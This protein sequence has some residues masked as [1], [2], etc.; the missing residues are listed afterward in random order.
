MLTITYSQA[1]VT[2]RSGIDYPA[3]IEN[4]EI[5]G[6]N[7]EP[8]HAVLMPYGNM[9]EALKANRRASTFARSLNGNWKFN[10]VPSPEKRPVDFYKNDY[11]VSKWADIPVPSNWEVHGY[12][13]PFYRN[14]G[15]TIKKD[16]PHIMSE[17]DKRYTA[18]VERNPVGSYKRNFDVPADWNGRR[19][20][21]SFDGVDAG[22]FLWVNGQKVG[23]SVNSRNAAEFDLTRYVKPGKNTI[24]AEVYQYTSGT[25]LEDQD[26]WRLHGIFRNVT[27]WSAP[28]THIRDFFIKPELDKNF[29]NATVSVE[30]KLK[31][32]SEQNIKAQTV[33]ATLYNSS[34]TEVAK[35]N[36]SSTALKAGQE[37]K[38]TLKFPVDN[39]AKW[40]AETPNLYTVVLTTNEGEILSQK[41][42]FRKLEIR[43]RV[44]LVNGVPLK[45]KGVNRHE[46]WSDVGHAVT[47]EQM[48]KDLEV[49][50]QGNCN[51]VRT[52][53]YSNDP[54]W[55]ELC[56]EW[57]IWLVAEANMEY[58]G[59]DRKFDEEPTIKAAIVD[60]N[61]ANVENFK[62]HP[63]VIIWSLGN[64]GGAGGTNVGAAL[65]AVKAIDSS[66]FVHYERYGTGKN[67]PADLDGR[68]YGTAQDYVR[69][70]QDK[71]L[72][73]PLYICE[74]VHAM[75]NSM[76][77]LNEYSDAFDN[78]PEILGG[79]IW[80][81]QDQ[82]LWNRRDPKHPILAY[83]GGFGEFPN[84]HY[85]I[86]K[87]VVAWD[88]I[89]VKPHYPEMKKAFQ[90]ISTDMTDATTGTIR[91]KNKFQ[92][93]SLE[94]F[95]GSWTLTENGVEISRGAFTLPRVG[96]L[97]EGRAFI[98]FKVERPKP[99]AEYFLRVSYTQNNKTLWAD[100]G[101][102]VAWDQ[103]KLPINT[104]AITTPKVTQPVGLTQNAQLI[105]INGNGFSV[106]FDKKSGL[107]S[108]LVKNGANLLL[109]GGGPKIHLWRAA[110]RND[111]MWAHGIWEKYG[112]NN[113][114]FSLVDLKAQAVD[115]FTVKV[116][117]TIKGEGKDGFGVYHTSTYVVK[118]DG[119]I[120]VNN[121]MDFIGLP[122][123]LGRIGV[124]MMLNQ[125]L[126]R[127]QYFGRGPYE[128]YSDRKS[129]AD[130][131]LYEL[132]V[133]EQYEY[134]KPMDRGNHEEVRWVKFNGNNTPN[135]LVKANEHHMQFTALPHT[136]EQMFPVEYKIDLPPSKATV[137]CLSTKTLGVG[138]ASCGPRP[139]EKFQVWANNVAFS[140]TL[141]LGSK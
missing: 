6:I 13:T 42:G 12:G 40:T 21:V 73:K 101:Y 31:N 11:D 32:Y 99:G 8:H 98:P 69:I 87:G 48:I 29:V 114:Q 71:Q 108:Q 141:Q 89:T 95:S 103:F 44:F 109:P 91:I 72:T 49:I 112:V 125:D 53:H 82:A 36:A 132:R 127:A 10:W 67:N 94:G 88:R 30:A 118:G 104:L 79:A 90:W 65:S 106:S 52:S 93:I 110:H 77:S 96:P 25:W 9:Q 27:L 133:N 70:A 139:L 55:Y 50:K 2:L 136:D 61:V 59:Y 74:F 1:Q 97:R 54:R 119:S 107:V 124:R 85:F 38:L 23:F 130:V 100:K 134:E 121:N 14:L 41:I 105:K 117:S 28:Q 126:N 45:L 84:D 92:F 35:S 81:F 4:P 80:E 113:L 102:E 137:F 76:G 62:N 111:D 51:H 140:Y 43:G 34:G 58:H 7:R 123:S 131:G 15:Y 138:S 24:A 66:R 86:H 129:S 20:F 68:M 46:H 19:I 22:F 116:T 3:E 63:S 122:I 115:M 135:L 17:P 16:F 18:F 60:R 78:T 128:N 37:Q 47:E 83:G 33:T 120:E 5:T 64:E 56:D 26:M 39:P 57:G 75:F